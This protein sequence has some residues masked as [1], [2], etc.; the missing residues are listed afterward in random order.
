MARV[1]N[2][3]DLR[4]LIGKVIRGGDGESIRP[5]S[6][7]LRLGSEGE[8]LNTA[9][10]FKLG[11]VKKG[12]I[13]PPGYSAGLTA[14]ETID[15]SPATVQAV[16][17]GCA[18][19]AFISPTTDMSR[20]GVVAPTTQVD[21]G[22]VGTINW[23]VTNTSNSERR[24]VF[25]ER[26]FR[27]TILLLEEG[28]VPEAYYE[29]DYQGQEG[30]VRS[31]RRGAP[32]GMRD[33]EWEDPAVE[34]GPESLLDDLLKAGYP[35]HA[36]GQRLKSVDDQFKMISNE[37]STIADSLGSLSDEV[38]S[39]GKQYETVVQQL[40]KTVANAL[41]EQAVALQ[42]RWLIASASM[43]AVLLGL[44]VSAVGNEM[45]FGFLKSNAPWI[46]LG[47]VVVGGT[48]LW[49]SQHRGSQ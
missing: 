46:G 10:E 2:D 41:G 16:F 48:V 8:F 22:F 1:L 49:V 14:L 31:A 13:I 34:G 47:L 35:W 40:P 18:M 7:I 45:V 37:Y 21:A 20:E 9:K 5:N 36:L 6:Y 27:L 3:A 30:Y 19:H 29:G 12:L 15:F 4:K 44:G 24:F 23:T 17:P 38:D 43:I 39:L 42:N 25:K 26:L 28:E 32:V 33:C 11:S